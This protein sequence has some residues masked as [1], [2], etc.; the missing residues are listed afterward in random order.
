MNCERPRPVDVE[1]A[2]TALGKSDDVEILSP[3]SKSRPAPDADAIVRAAKLL[4]GAERPLILAGG[5][6]VMGGAEVELIEL[7]QTLG[8]P[9]T[10]SYGGRG[11]ISDRHP[12]AIGCIRGGRVYGENPIWKVLEASDAVLVVGSR[13]SH[14]ITSGAGMKLP[15]T[16]VHLDIDANVFDKNFPTSIRLEGDAARGLSA[17]TAALK[18]IGKQPNADAVSIVAEGKSFSE[19]S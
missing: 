15:E 8:A 3:S 7:A 17:L 9:V 2:T 1:I 11:A 6:A 18:K 14:T 10:T 5:G 16:L 12:L 19:H 4:A 13:L